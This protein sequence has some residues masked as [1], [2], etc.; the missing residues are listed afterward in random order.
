MFLIFNLL[1]QL[2][3]FVWVPC[4]ISKLRVMQDVPH[5][6]HLVI[7]MEWG[8]RVPNQ[9]RE[10][11]YAILMSLR[12]LAK[13]IMEVESN[14]VFYSA[15]R[16]FLTDQRMNVPRYAGRGNVL[17]KYL[18]H[19]LFSITLFRVSRAH[20]SKSEGSQQRQIV[21]IKIRIFKGVNTFFISHM[22]VVQ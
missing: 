8:V 20:E 4:W 3:V 17:S 11:T 14:V 15:L 7:V 22:G 18:K 19:L 1:T 10:C 2:V 13:S 5:R 6:D 9:F 12:F 16:A 21:L